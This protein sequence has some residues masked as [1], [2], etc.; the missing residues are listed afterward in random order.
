MFSKC[1]HNYQK[2]SINYWREG[3]KKVLKLSDH[4]FGKLIFNPITGQVIYSMREVVKSFDL[5]NPE[6]ET[7]LLKKST[8]LHDDSFLYYL[9]LN[10]E[11]KSRDEYECGVFDFRNGKNVN[12][13]LSRDIPLKVDTFGNVMTVATAQ[14]IEIFD[15]RKLVRPFIKE[16]VRGARDFIF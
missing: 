2:H 16:S 10:L 11:N 3:V 1:H 13:W 14:G 7:T 15:T 8:F 5:D 4:P 9:T 12:T 6:K